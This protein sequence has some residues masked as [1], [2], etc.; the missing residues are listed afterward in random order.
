MLPYREGTCF[1]VPLDDQTFGLGVVARSSRWGR[2]V[3]GYFFGPRRATVPSVDSLGRLEPGSAIVAWRFSDVYLLETRWPIIGAHPRWVRELWPCPAYAR[4]DASTGRTTRVTYSDVH[5]A[6]VEREEEISSD[7][8]MAL[9]RD[10][11]MSASAVERELAEL[12]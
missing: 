10:V 2:V 11:L 6:R 3:A 5:P 12:L 7:V 9:E 1:A 4:S 8:G